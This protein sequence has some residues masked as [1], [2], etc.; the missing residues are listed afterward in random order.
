MSQVILRLSNA[1]EL[2]QEVIEGPLCCNIEAGKA[3]VVSSSKPLTDILKSRFGKLAGAHDAGAGRLDDGR[4][5]RHQRARHAARP[6]RKT[7]KRRTSTAAPNLGIDY[8]A[9]Q[10]RSSHGRRCRRAQRLARLNIK[11]ARLARIRSIAG[12]RTPLIFLAGP[13]P[14]ATYGA[15]VN[16]LSDREILA[17]WRNAAQAYTPRARPLSF[18]AHAAGG[19][20]DLARR[21]RGHPRVRAAGLAGFAIGLLG[22]RGWHAH[23]D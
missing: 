23:T 6:R 15:A 7:D 3:A 13:L 4:P 22:P 14:E 8:A 20:A 1:A 9:G 11:T 10:K 21:G 18:Q 17:I 19:N 12:R 5:R 16:G 2:V